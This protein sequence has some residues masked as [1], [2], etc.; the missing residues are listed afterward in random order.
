MALLA[1][2]ETSG[3]RLRSQFETRTGGT[4]P[5]DVGQVYTTLDRLARDG[6]VESAGEPDAEGRIAH[7]LTSA[8]HAELATWWST[9]VDRTNTPATSSPSS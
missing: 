5:L 7:G 3:A 6:L 8:G 4:W 2:G 1:E 9:P